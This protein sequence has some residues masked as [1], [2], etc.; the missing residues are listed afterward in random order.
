MM[1][2]EISQISTRDIREKES[3]N[4]L[5][6]LILC[7]LVVAICITLGCSVYFNTY[8]NAKK[9]YSDAVKEKRRSPTESV[10]PNVKAILE[11]AIQKCE[12]IVTYHPK[13]KYV[14]DAI[15]LMGK[16][17]FEMEDY[18]N[19]LRKIDELEI[20]FPDS[21][22]L[23]EALLLRGR[24]YLIQGN[25]SAAISSFEGLNRFSEKYYDIAQIEILKV[26]YGKGEYYEAIQ[27]GNAYLESELGARMGSSRKDVLFIIAQS[28][29]E[30]ARYEDSRQTF[31][32]CL[33]EDPP[34]QVVFDA[35]LK[36]GKSYLIQDSP[37][38][39]SAL[40]TFLTLSSTP[41]SSKEEAIIHL[42]IGRCQ[43]LLGNYE[44]GIATF[45]KVPKLHSRSQ[46][47]AEAYYMIGLIYEEDLKDLDKARESYEKV[48]KEN[49][50]ADVSKDAVVR[51][52]T[53][54]KLKDYREKLESGEEDVL[55]ETQFFLAEL[56][57]LELNKIDEAL[58]NYAKVIQEYPESEYSPRASYA[59]AWI[60][61]YL[62][63]DSEKAIEAYSKIMTKYPETRYSRASEKAIMQLK[64]EE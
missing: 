48:R 42:Q 59:I 27:Q 10:S 54:R 40:E 25:Y 64:P 36:I 19:T 28:L 29:F 3:R 18:E 61:N 16:C 56:Y 17:F 8:Y 23:E 5:S 44:E 1:N 2:H 38:A 21:P 50:Q 43:R 41:L 63:Q 35:T 31:L 53:I 62:K 49:L 47:S 55:A 12:K 6:V 14:D 37:H 51:A 32:D 34:P 13:S 30:V 24:A 39:D 15:Y 20:Y 60:Y 45:E 9:Y 33:R 26:H 58:E 7:N 11:K 46:E 22:F 4:I 57:L 52:A